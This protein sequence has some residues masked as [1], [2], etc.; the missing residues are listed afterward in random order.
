M[1]EEEYRGFGAA[2]I[3]KEGGVIDWGGVGGEPDPNAFFLDGYYTIEELLA[4]IAEIKDL[5]NKREAVEK[6]RYGQST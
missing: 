1:S 2:Q 5:P 4:L 3:K 6:I